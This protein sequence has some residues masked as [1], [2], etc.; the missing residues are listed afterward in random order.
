VHDTHVRGPSRSRLCI[1]DHLVSCL[2]LISLFYL[3]IYSSFPPLPPPSLSLLSCFLQGRSSLLKGYV[4]YLITDPNSNDHTS[5]SSLTEEDVRWMI[6]FCGGTVLNQRFCDRCLS[7][8]ECQ[9]ARRSVSF[10]VL[11]LVLL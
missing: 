4:F 7:T 1:R 6:Y 5:P 11:S 8:E 9:I 10:R 3:L 2:P